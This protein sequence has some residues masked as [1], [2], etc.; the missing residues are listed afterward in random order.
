MLES[1]PQFNDLTERD[2]H[3][4]FQSPCRNAGLNH[5]M[6]SDEDFEGDPRIAGGKADIGAD[7]YYFHLYNW[8][9]ATPGGNVDLRIAGGPGMPVLLGHSLT[10]HNPPQTTTWGDLYLTLPPRWSSNIGTIP[11]SGILAFPVT[12]PSF[13]NPGDEK[14]FQAL[15]GATG[16][17]HTTLTNLLTLVVE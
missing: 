7:E 10:I 2:L 6:L 15:V 4:T 14:Y 11:S 13:W 17:S 3:L 8:G 16:G 9:T 12:V 5:P 1:D